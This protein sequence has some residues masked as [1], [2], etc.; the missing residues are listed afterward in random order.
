M[1]YFRNSKNTTDTQV[2][3]RVKNEIGE[4]VITAEIMGQGRP[5]QVLKLGRITRDGMLDLFC[6]D[7]V[8]ALDLGIALDANGFMITK[9]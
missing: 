4:V 2:V 7:T 1:S 5:S 8:H 6:L 3:I 9:K